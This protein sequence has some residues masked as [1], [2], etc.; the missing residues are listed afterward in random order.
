MPL[1]F[2][3][4]DWQRQIGTEMFRCSTDTQYIQLDRLNEAL[5]SDALWWATELPEDALQMMVENSLCFGLYKVSKARSPD[6]TGELTMIGLSRVI[7]DNVTFGYLTDVYVVD[8]HQR[9]GLAKFMMECLDE[10]LNHLTHLRR[11]LILSRD[12][13]AISMYKSTLRAKDWQPPE[14]IKLL[15]R[16]GLSKKLALAESNITGYQE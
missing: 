8:E 13:G 3:P 11:L 16:P 15:A 1:T 14:D 12:Q 9:K 7:T 5:A 10:V 2:K 6:Q 4:Q